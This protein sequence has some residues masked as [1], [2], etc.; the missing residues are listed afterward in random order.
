MSTQNP[1]LFHTHM[2]GAAGLALALQGDDELIRPLT[3][4]RLS[5]ANAAMELVSDQIR[6]L[7][8]FSSDA[9]IMAVLTLGAHAEELDENESGHSHPLSPLATV[10]NLHAFGRKA[11]AHAHIKALKVLFHQKGGYSGIEL[12]GLGAL[13]YL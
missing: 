1:V 12:R 5:H 3:M 6:H 9:L 7:K 8:G 10:Q 4:F 11:L 2:S 13:V